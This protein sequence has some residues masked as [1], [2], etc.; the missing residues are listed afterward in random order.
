MYEFLRDLEGEIG[1]AETLN[2][3]QSSMSSD[4]CSSIS[5]LSFDDLETSA[6]TSSFTRLR[7]LPSSPTGC[8]TSRGKLYVLP[9]PAARAG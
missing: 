8:R 4:S 1:L 9:F 5:R 3:S 6:K 2:S 7:A